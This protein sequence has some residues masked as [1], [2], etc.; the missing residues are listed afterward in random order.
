MN[1]RRCEPQPKDPDFTEE[2][3]ENEEQKS[4]FQLASISE[5]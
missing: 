3:E 2:N 1:A 5:D 4:F